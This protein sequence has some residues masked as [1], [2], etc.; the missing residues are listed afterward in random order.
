MKMHINIKQPFI[1]L[2]RK[3]VVVQ[4]KYRNIWWKPSFVEFKKKNKRF[5]ID[6]GEARMLN[7]I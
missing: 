3:E 1:V 4:L 5:A 6:F 7:I 2:R